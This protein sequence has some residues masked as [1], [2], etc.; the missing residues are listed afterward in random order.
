MRYRHPLP[1]IWLMTDERIENID[2]AIARLPRRSGIVFRHYSLKPKARRALFDRVRR[3]AR[4]YHHILLLAG[5]PRQAR[6]WQAD[7]A[8]DRSPLKSLGRRSAA[9]HSV[10]ERIAATRAGAD[11]LFVSPVFAT[12]SHPHARVLGRIGTALVAGHDRSRTVALGGM[13]AKRAKTLSGLRIHG[14]AAIDALSWN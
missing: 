1:R 4:R 10:R 8:H 14:W 6:A 5:T 7:G 12:R 9:V 3:A 13:T 11:V 2:T